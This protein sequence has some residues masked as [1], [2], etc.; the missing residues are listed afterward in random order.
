MRAARIDYAAYVT[1]NDIALWQRFC[2]GIRD[3]N[4]V[5]AT[6]RAVTLDIVLAPLTGMAVA[7]VVRSARFASIREQ[8]TAM[9]Q[10]IVR[11][12]LRHAQQLGIHPRRLLA[13]FALEAAG[14]PAHSSMMQLSAGE[15][16]VTEVDISG[17]VH[18]SKMRRAEQRAPYGRATSLLL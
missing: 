18:Q 6:L 2:A 17:P 15:N 4:A 16:I 9:Y 3:D 5:V 11:A 8:F 13:Y 7:L 1:R 12:R 14:V 10:V